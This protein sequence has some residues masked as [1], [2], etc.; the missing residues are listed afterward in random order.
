[1][2]TH[3]LREEIAAA[4]ARIASLRE[5]IATLERFVELKQMQIIGVRFLA[6]PE[7]DLMMRGASVRRPPAVYGEGRDAKK[8]EIA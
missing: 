4:E 7:A 1:M 5:E 2:N 3:I 6:H 8:K